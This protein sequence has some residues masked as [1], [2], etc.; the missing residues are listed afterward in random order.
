MVDSTMKILSKK[1]NCSL[2]PISRVSTSYPNII[3]ITNLL[4]F[5][6]NLPLRP[7]CL[8]CWHVEGGGG[9]GAGVQVGDGGTG[10]DKAVKLEREMMGS[11]VMGRSKLPSGGLSVCG[12]DVG[13]RI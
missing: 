7:E 9:G 2:R 13:W 4:G 1:S 12:L 8:H 10:G 3:I 5:A 11:W 6:S